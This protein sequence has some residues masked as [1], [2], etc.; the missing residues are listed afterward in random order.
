MPPQ[1]LADKTFN[2]TPWDFDFKGFGR[3]NS[4]SYKKHFHFCLPRILD[5]VWKVWK[6]VLIITLML[7]CYLTTSLAYFKVYRII[8]WSLWFWCYILLCYFLAVSFIILSL[9]ECIND[10]FIQPRFCY[11]WRMIL[12]DILI[13]V[14]QIF[15]SDSSQ[16]TLCS[17]WRDSTYFSLWM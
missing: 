6:Y 3:G 17:R 2:R 9:V 12:N 13:V 10:F 16:S 4:L 8:R 11:L 5:N 14:K 15:F 7:S 1:F